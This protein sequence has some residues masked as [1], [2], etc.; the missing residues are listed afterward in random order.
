MIKHLCNK[1]CF[2][3]EK[4]C[5]AT[6]RL[7][8]NPRQSCKKT[9]FSSRFRLGDR[10]KLCICCAMPAVVKDLFRS[11]GKVSLCNCETFVFSVQAG[12][13]LHTNFGCTYMCFVQ[14]REFKTPSH[15]VSKPTVL[16]RR[17]NTGRLAGCI[18]IRTFRRP[19]CVQW[20]RKTHGQSL[21]NI[22]GLP[23]SVDFCDTEKVHEHKEN[24]EHD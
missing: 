18:W 13:A 4:K 20:C 19:V 3:R 14:V 1:R 9:F 23:L 12:R 24:N 17:P 15:G 8:Y 21:S 11:V 7:W 22:N 16:A 2:W 5:C 6:R 10:T